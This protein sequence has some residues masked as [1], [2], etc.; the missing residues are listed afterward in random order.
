MSRKATIGYIR[1]EIPDFEIPT[2]MGERYEAMV[3]D[4]L[5]L[6]ERAEL[7]IN[8]LTGPTDPEADYEIYFFVEFFSNPPAMQ[9]D[10]S[11]ICV[12][13]FMESLP[14]LRIA[15]GSDLNSHVDR[16]WME[17]ILK[18]IGPDGLWYIPT[19][20]IPWIRLNPAWANP[21]R[22][23]DG[24]TTDLSDET[25]TQFAE[26]FLCGRIIGA[27]TVHY[28][29]DQNPLWK[30][31]IGRMIQRLSQLTIDKGDYCYFPAGSFE[32][33]AKVSPDV[34][35]P[36]GIRASLVGW[37]IQGLAQYYRVSGHDPA[38]KL[39]GKLVT[40]LKDYGKW[41]DS[42]GRFLAGRGDQGVIRYVRPEQLGGHHHHHDIC[43][44]GMIEYA[45]ITK[46]QEL[47][48]FVKKS[49]EWAR[50]QGS[51]L[52]GFFP[53]HIVP[54]YP[55]SEICEVADLIAIALKITEAGVGDYWDD[56]DRY[57]RNQFAENQ[58]TQI[59]W[60]DRI[61]KPQRRRPIDPDETSD[62]VAERN[63]G[64]FAGWSSANDWAIRRGIMH[65][66]TGNGTRAIY[67]VWE[68]ILHYR[69]GVLRLNML[70]NRSSPWADVDSYIPY[71]GKV[72]IK[73]K[74][75]CK[76]VLVRV[77]EWI[78]SKSE[79]AACTVNGESRKFLWNGRYLNVGESKS[80]DTVTVTFPIQERTVKEFIGD[81]LYT[82]IIKGN[83]VVFI[84]PL[85]KNCPLYQRTHY[86]E[87]KVRWVKRERFVPKENIKW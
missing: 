1:N 6:A 45:L 27:M 25:V 39:A 52:V 85:G 80:G 15:T 13:K 68:N 12:C 10:Y 77:P 81:R 44:L 26:P 19:G 47:M 46:D 82:L 70:L 34:E 35:M 14:L 60:I 2:Y 79:K 30:E 5:D 56:V 58:L 59:D 17:V 57:T 55:S 22:R 16:A 38:K 42:E 54:F 63:L 75:P 32:P 9:H 71:E 50:T 8:G 21:V 66:C 3:P 28:L 41:F 48:E 69:D 11:D 76:S 36:T 43:L 78:E 24:T 4:T 67:Y 23:A 37:T 83:E 40:Y 86:R 73:V 65:C 20:G 18:S 72:D 74:Q 64:A 33:N 49:Y 7:G 51:S 61:F 31:T 62:R 87:N 53:T 84:D 29:R